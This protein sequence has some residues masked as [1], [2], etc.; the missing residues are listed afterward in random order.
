MN[1]LGKIIG[2]P[3][4]FLHNPGGLG[5]GIIQVITELNPQKQRDLLS[6][7]SLDHNE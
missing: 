3:S 2:L 4:D 1:W 7:F 6:F 5:G